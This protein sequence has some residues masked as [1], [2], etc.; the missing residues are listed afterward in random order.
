MSNITE[1]IRYIGVVREAGNPIF[2]TYLFIA[3]DLSTVLVEVNMLSN[4]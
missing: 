2:G 1:N 3:E 4:P